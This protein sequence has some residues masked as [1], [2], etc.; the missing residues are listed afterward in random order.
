V[1]RG[2][3]VCQTVQ[4][5]ATHYLYI[6]TLQA[7]VKN[8]LL[9]IKVT[10]GIILSQWKIERRTELGFITRFMLNGERKFLKEMGMIAKNAVSMGKNYALTM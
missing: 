7:F 3:A 6:K 9:G 5:A 4:Y 8:V 10:G 1:K 2:K